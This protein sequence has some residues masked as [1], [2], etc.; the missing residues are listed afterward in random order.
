MPSKARLKS[1]FPLPTSAGGTSKGFIEGL[2]LVYVGRNALTVEA[3]SAYVPSLGK[4][5]DVPT[6]IALT[7]MTFT[8][9]TWYH[10]YLYDSGGGVGAIEYSNTGPV[11]YFGKSYNKTGDTSRRYLGSVLTGSGSGMFK[12][13]HDTGT[14]QMEYIEGT[15]TTI[16]FKLT[17]AWGGTTPGAQG[18][19]QIVPFATT[20]HIHL[21]V[22]TL[23]LAYFGLPEQQSTPNAGQFISVVGNGGTTNLD[24]NDIWLPCSRVLATLSQHLIWVQAVAGAQVTTWCY[25]YRYER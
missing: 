1:Q 10:V 18:V 20:T 3:G 8:A 4:V 17:D 16:P 22:Q 15:P 14:S 13:Y 21:G 6:D 11:R 12:F 24:I 19:T 9:T 2:R 23:G 25:G 5:L 7:G